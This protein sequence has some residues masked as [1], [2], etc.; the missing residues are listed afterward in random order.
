MGPKYKYESKSLPLLPPPPLTHPTGMGW[1]G[2]RGS[3]APSFSVWWSTEQLHKC[4]RKEHFDPR[5]CVVCPQGNI[6][7]LL[8]AEGR[9]PP[10]PRLDLVSEQ[11]E[12]K[13][14]G[15]ASP[16]REQSHS[17]VTSLQCHKQNTDTSG[18]AWSK[19]AALRGKEHL[20]KTATLGPHPQLSVEL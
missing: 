15:L 13:G 19:A 5:L 14:Q 11:M 8:P 17:S 4:H 20:P 18:K 3:S 10:F 12:G 1:E 9:C 6:P 2:G 16:L 7:A